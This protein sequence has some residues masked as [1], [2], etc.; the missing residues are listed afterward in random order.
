MRVG[1]P[2]TVTVAYT[3]TGAAAFEP[4][5]QQDVVVNLGI[6]TDLQFNVQGITVTE[7]VVVTAV[8]DTVM[9]SQR[10]GAATSVSREMLATLPTVSNRLQDIVR[11]T[12]Q[13][14]GGLS[15][16]G[17]D[18]RANNITVD[19]AY[20][21]NSFGLNS[22]PGDRS[23]V[24]PISLSA[25]EQ[26]QVN[27]APFDVRQGNF[28]GA[29]VNSVTRSGTN[30]F[31][32]SFHREWRNEGLVGTEARGL[33]FNPGTFTYGN[34]GAWGSGPVWQNK[35][36]FFANY[37]DEK[38][39]QPGTTFRANQ[40]GEPA[41]GSVTRVLTTDLDALSSFLNQRFNYETGP[42]Q[43][44]EHS[45]PA[46]RFLTKFDYNINNS[47]KVSFRYTQLDSNSDILL[48]NSSS[49]GF[50]T[51]RT[52]LFGLNFQNSN[53]QQI[54]DI[55]SGVGEWNAIIGNTMA[56]NLIVG[57]S[58]SDESRGSR[59]TFFPLVDVLE[60]GSVYTSFGFEPFT[61]NN[62]LRYKS[63][64]IKDD[65]TKF[66]D[67][68]S[69]TL[70][71]TFQKYNSENVFFSGAQSIYVY[72]SLA[73]FY[74][75]ANGHLANPNRTVSP[76]SLE[77][78]Q[79]RWVN[80]PGLDKP[81]QPLEVYYSGAYAQDEW[82]A[83]D[84]FKLTAGVRFDV[85]KF[86]DTGF[87]NSRADA[88]T[89]RDEDGQPV[90]Y[91][92][93]KL[94]DPKFL[95]SP[96]VGFNWDVHK[97]LNT[98]LRGGTGIFTGPPPYVWISNQIGTTGVLTGFEDLR[99]T[100]ARPFHPDPNRY[101]P[102]N[103]TGAP[104]S[105][106]E[107]AITDPDFKFPQTWRSN[108]GLDRRLPWGIVGT[109]E[110]I[111][112]KDV[113]GVYYINANLP[114]AQSAFVGP[115][116][117]PR[118]TGPACIA[119]GNVGGCSNRINSEPGN[120]VQNAIVLKNSNEGRS[121]NAAFSGRKLYRGGFVQAAYSYGEAKT[122]VDPSTIASGSWQN[123]QI[124][125]D[126]NNPPLAFAP[127]SPGHR[128]FTT[129]SYTSNWFKFG[130][131]TV[132]VFFEARTINNTSYTFSGDLNGDTGTNNDLIYIHR[133]I[134]EMNFAQFT[135]AATGR[136][137]TPAE[138][139]QAWEAYIAQ[140]PYL[141][142]RRG[143][144]AERNA[145]FLPFVRRLD[146]SVA[147]DLFTNLGGRRHSVQFRVDALN[148]GNLLNSNWGVG[149]RLV[150]NQPLTNPGV[151]AQGR[152]TYRLRLINN[153]LLTARSY[154]TTTFESDVY[155]IKFSVRYTFN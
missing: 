110:F 39:N 137:F 61:P 99:N 128:F 68:H 16:A 56:N 135:V 94:P 119:A 89:F 20:F 22:S 131:T 121:W 8:S 84:N 83:R 25:I 104:A 15:F 76:V 92:T 130:S 41:A 40:G 78:F 63:F 59:G 26:I 77:R 64:Q 17:Q 1:G 141:S 67:K 57:Y 45:T 106:Y 153:Q 139:A 58:Y 96:R 140:D 87:E 79:V 82:S 152:A 33:P 32:G 66:M 48:S 144:Y 102:T 108:I 107:L 81:L 60:G 75:D 129:A 117:R 112:N 24:A 146:F 29:G 154:E 72:N 113:N 71:G 44:Y 47:N 143:Q 42:Y 2:Y 95:W 9:S 70:G 109:A 115:D 31:R 62:E 18:A 3:G 132:S 126:P 149:Q 85:P 7:T 98:Q 51:R 50:G 148:F 73:D 150:S 69:I 105:S 34:T 55:K 134:S 97:N 100:T 151:D 5:T 19:G 35:L 116:N 43:G 93:S 65:F 145:V 86:S 36:F 6:A 114:G 46:K 136:T 101:K 122:I 133:D 14:G 30:Q 37:E 111:Y 147:Q 88:L 125:S 124:P 49:L 52:N 11:V 38:F 27:V 120:I 74:T 4:Q 53:Y 21:N 80:I 23:G 142:E 90:Q 138:Q 10:T 28:I 54:E 127:T 155:R 123:N 91:N 12:P 118:W 103:V 13:S